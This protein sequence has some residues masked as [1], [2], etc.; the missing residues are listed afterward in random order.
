MFGPEAQQCGLRNHGRTD[1]RLPGMVGVLGGE[2]QEQ[3]V[4]EVSVRRRK[5]RAGT[6]AL[7]QSCCIRASSRSFSI[8]WCENSPSAPEHTRLSRVLSP[9]DL[10]ASGCFL[11]G[12][13][14]SN[15]S[16]RHFLS[17]PN[18]PAAWAGWPLRSGCLSN[19]RCPGLSGVRHLVPV[20]VQK[21][22]LAKPQAFAAS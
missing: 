19:P 7:S 6:R 13:L 12:S 15:G 14:G 16:P 5:G 1:P 4:P 21:S 10:W 8:L 11:L 22:S 17:S 9:Q 2:S 18:V 20:L 3:A